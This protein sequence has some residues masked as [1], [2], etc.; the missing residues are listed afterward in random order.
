MKGRNGALVSILGALILLA[1]IGGYFLLLAPSDSTEPIIKPG[2]A[3][4][5]DGNPFDPWGDKAGDS[6]SG[7]QAAGADPAGLSGADTK[8]LDKKVTGADG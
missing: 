7:S 6:K 1:M 4:D 2:V 3:L 5:A 8:G